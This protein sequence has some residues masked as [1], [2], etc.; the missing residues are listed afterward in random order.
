MDI[1]K[2]INKPFNNN[3][4]AG[5]L[6]FEMSC[7]NE[8]IITNCGNLDRGYDKG[9]EYL[10]FSA[11]H[12]TIVL[13]NTNISELIEKKSYKR[14]PQN[15]HINTYEDNNTI[16]W[17]A[18]HDGYIKNYKK[19]I[20]RKFTISKNTNAIFG[21]DEI[22]STKITKNVDNYSIR[23]H[24]FPNI[25]CLLTNDK[26][27][28]LFKT[29]KNQSWVFKSNSDILIEDSIYVGGGGVVEQNKQI[30]IYGTIKNSKKIEKWSIIKK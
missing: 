6:S 5:T 1:F 26:K 24:L 3:F 4:H 11:A 13:N 14:A 20:K 19:I 16:T 30:V 8:K 27:T 12:S 23:F 28:V 9:Q 18:S 2:P 15:I 29:K 21:Q 17:E 7:L 10:R 22:M 25:N